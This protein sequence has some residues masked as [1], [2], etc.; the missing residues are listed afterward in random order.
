MKKL[1]GKECLCE[2]CE[3]RFVCFTADKVFSDR[4][5]QA[6]YESYVKEYGRAEALKLMAQWM[7]EQ[8]LSH[9]RSTTIT[10]SPDGYPWTT[11]TICSN[12]SD[13]EV[14]SSAGNSSPSFS[15]SG[16]CPKE[17]R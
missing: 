17:V 8:I 11:W 6:L 16:W 1:K 3:K 4:E 5:F 2:Q 14:S 12:S 10:S 9:L 15:A 7:Q 13:F